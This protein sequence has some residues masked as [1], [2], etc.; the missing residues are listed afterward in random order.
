MMITVPQLVEELA[1]FNAKLLT[2]DNNKTLTGFENLSTCN[3]S[4]VSDKVVYLTDVFM[5]AKHLPDC[6]EVTFLVITN[7]PVNPVLIR[8]VDDQNCDVIICDSSHQG[9]D[10]HQRLNLIFDERYAYLRLHKALYDTIGHSQTLHEILTYAESIFLNPVLMIDSNFKVIDYAKNKKMSDPIWLE[11]CRRGYCSYEFVKEVISYQSVLEAPESEVPFTVVCHKSQ[12]RK[13]VSKI[14]FEG[15]LYGFMIVLETDAPIPNYKEVLLSD[16][17][18]VVSNYLRG[19]VTLHLDVEEKLIIDLIEGHIKT[20][21]ELAERKKASKHLFGKT[22]RLLLIK[23]K[24]KSR[25]TRETI[26]R[27]LYQIFPRGRQVIYQEHLL[28]LTTSFGEEMEEAVARERLID[29]L[30]EHN[31]I[32]IASEVFE[33]PLALKELYEQLLESFVIAERLKNTDRL[34]GFQALK[35]YHLINA[36]LA[37]K[38]MLGLC[39]TELLKLR[40]RDQNEHT[41]YYH[42]LHVFLQHNGSI[43]RTADALYIHRNTLQNRMKKIRQLLNLDLEDGE[44]VFQLM[45]SFKVLQFVKDANEGDSF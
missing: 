44:T 16:I 15:K 28:V 34:I 12:T 13:R 6:F 10:V 1:A 43:A 8:Q 4:S 35:F 30:K 41:D 18:K 33:A 32:A 9:N 11:I 2:Y 36:D 45:Y 24:G 27:A 14:I 22:N 29:T 31:L 38:T 20:K 23:S 25:A 19:K 42:S 17:S 40:Q 37:E 26:E 39:Q 21:E 7:E 3:Q 5:L